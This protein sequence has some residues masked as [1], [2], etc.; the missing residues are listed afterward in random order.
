VLIENRSP[1]VASNAAAISIIPRRLPQRLDLYQTALYVLVF[2]VS[3]RRGPND[4][5]E[6]SS[7][8]GQPGAFQWVHAEYLRRDPKRRII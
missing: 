7:P 8:G 3:V 6:S 4:P 2:T 1:S 5:V